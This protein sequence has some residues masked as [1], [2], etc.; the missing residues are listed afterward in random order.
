M[1]R[2]F[3]RTA[4]AALLLTAPSTLAAGWPDLSSPP[5]MQ[6]GGEQDAALLISIGDYV[7]LPDVYGAGDNVRDWYKWLK[8]TRGVGSVKVLSDHAAT[9]EAILD[10][11]RRAAL[12]VG[13]GGTMWVLFIGHG[14]PSQDGQDG[15]LIG[16]DAQLTAAGLYARSLSRTELLY[17][18]DAGAQEKTVVV[19]DACFSGQREGGRA[20]VE[21][22][23]P[24]LLSGSWRPGRAIVLSAAR[25]DQ[26]AGPLP[27]AARPAFSYL[28]LG[29]LRGWGDTNKDGEITA[30]EAMS[31]TS[32]ALYEVVQDRVQEPE[33]VG[34]GGAWVLGNGSESAPDL[35]DHIRTSGGTASG[36]ETPEGHPRVGSGGRTVDIQTQLAQLERARQEREAAEATAAEAE[37]KEQELQARMKAEREAKLDSAEAEVAREAAKMWTHVADLAGTGGPEARQAV[38]LFL[39]QYGAA[40]VWVEDTSGRYERAVRSAEIER[41]QMWMD[42]FERGTD[43]DPDALV[44]GLDW[45]LIP[46]GRFRM[47]TEDGNADEAPVR[48]ILV[49][50]FEMTR[51]EITVAQYRV[52]VE[53][54]VCSEPESGGSCNWG[55]ENHDQHPINCVDWYQAKTFAEWAGGRLP[56]E[57]EW[58]YAARGGEQLTY[59]GSDDVEEVAWYLGNSSGHSS[60]VC[61]LSANGFGLCDMSGNMW[62]W[63]ED[64]YHSNYA[65]APM[66]ADVWTESSGPHRVRRGGSWS[67]GKKRLRVTFR[68]R[69]EP[70]IMRATTGFRIVR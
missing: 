54:G 12:K 3:A 65:G 48:E 47:G 14:A 26:F 27:G 33:L 62:E 11:A 38:G 43:A 37:R 10:E 19:M 21:G 1:P 23:Q 46:G 36:A 55:R 16:A 56:S 58:E 45:L 22:L 6:G 35:A 51:S 18:L 52:C 17:A 20:L 41:A 28:L 30:A 60:R 49:P 5:P 57:A 4:L 25:G 8:E 9:R 53:D 42:A 70:T 15:V 7:F 40:V 13:E 2:T 63:V 61:E 31:W 34:R 64:V 59:A 39:Q 50:S 68:H 66:S 44:A 32:D 69:D 67:N 24:S 29:A